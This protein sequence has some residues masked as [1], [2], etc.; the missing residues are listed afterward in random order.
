[1]QTA[2]CDPA[3]VRQFQYVV[4]CARWQE[5]WLLVRHRDRALL[6]MPGG[7]VE[8]GENPWQ[9]ASRELYE[10]TGARDF[11][12]T[13]AGAY[14]VDSQEGRTFG[15]LFLGEVR[16]LGPLPPYEIAEVVPC[17]DWPELNYP[18]I[19]PLLR[20]RALAALEA[21]AFMGQPNPE[22][23]CLELLR[24]DGLRDEAL[25]RWA[26]RRMLAQEG[27]ITL[28]ECLLRNRREGM[29]Y[30]DVADGWQLLDRIRRGAWARSEAEERLRGVLAPQGPFVFQDPG[31]LRDGELELVCTRQQPAQPETGH[32]PC[33]EFALRCGG[34]DA[35]QIRLRVGYNLTLYYTGHI[36]YD[37]EPA[38]RGR[39]LAVRACRLLAPLARAHGLRLLLITNAWDNRPS[40]RVCE[41][42]GA[43]FLEQAPTPRWHPLYAEGDRWGNVFAWMLEPDAVQIGADPGDGQGEQ[44][45]QPAV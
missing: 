5:R 43:R 27:A 7:H 2:F 9:A 41:K 32:V 45:P 21:R 30:R 22:R 15:M 10:E 29:R 26:V 3:N 23:R 42:L 28:A 24:Q 33:Y 34:Q 11:T 31:P 35:G 6:E 38:F 40:R 19:Q 8:P 44:I 13:P 17:A 12:L 1:M 18:D 39:G 4:I 20:Q 14:L 16:E 37:V 36:G 25:G